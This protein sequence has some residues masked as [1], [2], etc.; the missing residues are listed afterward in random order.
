MARSKV[1]KLP[2]GARKSL[3]DWLQEFLAGR[4]SLDEVMERLEALLVFNG[5]NDKPSRSAV[6]RYAQKFS[7]V[8]DRM[9]RAQQFREVLVR[10]VGPQ[11]ADGKGLQVMAQAFESLVYDMLAGMEEGQTFTPE[12]LMFFAKSIQSVAGAL[13]TDADRALRIEETAL[14]KAAQSA[15]AEGQALGLTEDQVKKIEKVILGVE[16]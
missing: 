7:A 11:V 8:A 14:K 13:K 6:G 2:E 15:K 4:M 1:E 3:E 12:Q 5:V 10:E 9:K 16:R